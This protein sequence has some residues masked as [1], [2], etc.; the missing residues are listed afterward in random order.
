MKIL[1]KS[2]SESPKETIDK[3]LNELSGDFR[4]IVKNK[5]GN[6]FC[7]DLLKVCDKNQ[8]IKILKEL[9]PTISEDCTDEFG[10]HPIQNLIELASSEEEYN[11]FVANELVFEILISSCNFLIK[12]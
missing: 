3:I 5:N 6:Y 7:T 9:S 11:L 8:R 4:M 1:Q 10:T 2:L 12:F